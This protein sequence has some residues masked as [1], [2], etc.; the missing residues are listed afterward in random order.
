MRRTTLSDRFSDKE[1][2]RSRPLGVPSDPIIRGTLS[3]CGCNQ[4]HV[5]VSPPVVADPA[6]ARGST[7]REILN[8]ST[9]PEPSAEG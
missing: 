2:D 7:V 3:L 9:Q 5:L 1:S 4:S 8:E 6:G